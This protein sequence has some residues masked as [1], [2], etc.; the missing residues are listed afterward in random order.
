MGRPNNSPVAR[1]MAGLVLLVLMLGAGI[2]AAF[3][4]AG[5]INVSLQICGGTLV[6]AILVLVLGGLI[7]GANRDNSA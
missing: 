6:V 2:A 3:G 4:T 5:R 7:V 1:Q